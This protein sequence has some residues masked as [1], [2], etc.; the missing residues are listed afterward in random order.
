MKAANEVLL[1]IL[2]LC[3]QKDRNDDDDN[4]NN[5]QLQNNNTNNDNRINNKCDENIG[6]LSDM[7]YNLMEYAGM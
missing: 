1:K 3:I 4:T 2:S 6:V 7:I 5:N